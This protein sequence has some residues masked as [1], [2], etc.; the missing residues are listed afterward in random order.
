MIST[1]YH[2]FT[3]LTRKKEEEEEVELEENCPS[4][5][6]HL[7]SVDV[8]QHESKVEENRKNRP[9]CQVAPTS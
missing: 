6:G 2:H 4:L 9:A 1:H 5:I 7:T 3:L 8:K